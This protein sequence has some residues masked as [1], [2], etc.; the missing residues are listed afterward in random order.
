MV[1]QKKSATTIEE[2]QL[3]GRA[4]RFN[5]YKFD[6]QVV[7]NRQFDDDLD[8]E[9]RLLEEFFY[10]TYDDEKGYISDLKSVLSDEG[11][12]DTE[13]NWLTFGKNSS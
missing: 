11:Y 5:P 8:N 13:K 7:R 2:K 6:N 10:F 4:V 1:L 3:I 9:L 12:I